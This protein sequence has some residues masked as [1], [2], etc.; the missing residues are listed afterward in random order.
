MV[1]NNSFETEPINSIAINNENAAI[2]VTEYLINLG[3]KNIATI[4]G[5]LSTESG[6]KRL[7]GFKSAMKSNSLR[8]S[9]KYITVGHYLRSPARKATEALLALS[10]PPTAIF[11]AS[12]VM[13]MEAIDVVKKKGLRVPEDVSIVGFDDNPLCTYS[14]VPLTT[15]WQPIVEMGRL[16]VELLYQILTGAKKQP[17][18]TLLKTKLIERSSCAAL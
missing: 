4:A 10:G 16:G 5:D 14:P 15:V 2:E 6:K 8:L 7:E 12:D 18:K 9:T 1:L 17:V 13:A 11:C 3:H